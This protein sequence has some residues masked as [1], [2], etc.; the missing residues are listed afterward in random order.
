MS[1][2]KAVPS[3]IVASV[4]G[5]LQLTG[6]VLSITSMA[7]RYM[8]EVGDVVVGRINEVNGTRWKC[9]IGGLQDAVMMLNNVTEPGGVLRRRGRQDELSMRS[10][11][12]EDDVFVAEVQRVSNTDNSVN[13]HT[14]SVEKYGKMGGI[15]TLVE[16]KQSLVPQ[17]KR[18]FITFVD[19]NPNAGALHGVYSTSDATSSADEPGINVVFGVNGGIWI[20]AATASQVALRRSELLKSENEEEGLHAD[21]P[22]AENNGGADDGAV[23]AEEEDTRALAHADL[24][25]PI[26]NT[27]PIHVIEKLAAKHRIVALVSSIVKALND[28]DQVISPHTVERALKEV[29]ER[30]WS[31]ADLNTSRQCRVSLATTIEAHVHANAVSKKKIASTRSVTQQIGTKRARV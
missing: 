28:L 30:N 11:F 20:A 23:D 4:S 8:A 24:N 16:V 27:T 13:L 5:V 22:T 15:G 14:R 19:A 31:I 25:T 26:D 17:T 9:N 1:G 10:I 2:V 29:F 21:L 7:P 6:T 12:Q 18:Q 3:G